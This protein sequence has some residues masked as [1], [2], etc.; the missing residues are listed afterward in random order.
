[1][2]ARALLKPEQ[3]AAI[4]KLEPPVIMEMRKIL[5][6]AKELAEGGELTVLKPWYGW[7]FRKADEMRTELGI[8]SILNCRTLHPV[9]GNREGYGRKRICSKTGK[10][11]SR[12]DYESGGQEFESLRAR[13][14]ISAQL[15]T[16]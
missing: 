2:D 7:W 4:A 11:Y 3:S 15:G 8:V 6:A 1:M 12:P 5:I 16:E 14:L 13:H 9:R 10:Q